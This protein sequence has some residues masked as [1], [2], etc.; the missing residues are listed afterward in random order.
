MVIKIKILIFFSWNYV[1]CAISVESGKTR[2]RYL[3][4]GLA[5]SL[6]IGARVNN[7]SNQGVPNIAEPQFGKLKTHGLNF[8][9]FRAG[10]K[11]FILRKINVRVY[12][13]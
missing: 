5:S 9:N 11:F 13:V 7:V 10:Q 6:S 1:G 3:K 2:S 8:Q 12:M 4:K